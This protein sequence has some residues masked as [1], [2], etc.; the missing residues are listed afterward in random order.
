[1]ITGEAKEIRQELMSKGIQTR[2][3]IFKLTRKRPPKRG[4]EAEDWK[5]YRSWREACLRTKLGQKGNRKDFIETDLKRDDHLVKK[6]NK[7]G[8][9]ELGPSHRRLK[10]G[11]GKRENDTSGKGEE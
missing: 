3:A 10:L 2:G 1:L 4:E 6:K 9:A 8:R 7:H 11:S 5:K